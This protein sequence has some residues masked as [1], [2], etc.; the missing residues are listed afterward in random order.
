MNN[1]ALLISTYDNSEDLWIPLEHTYLKF[2]ND[3]DFPIYLNVHRIDSFRLDQ[4][5]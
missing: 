4:N 2:W 5:F 3:I 1:I